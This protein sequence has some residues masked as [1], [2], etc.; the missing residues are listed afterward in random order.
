MF[1]YLS[2]SKYN[3]YINSRQSFVDRYIYGKKFSSIY[4][5][6]GK[7]IAEGLEHRDTKTNSECVKWA[8][9]V[10]P[11]PKEREKKYFVDI[12]GVPLF[13]ILDGE[14][15]GI[16]HEYKTGMHS[17][18]QSKVDENGQLTFYAMMMW[19]KTGKLPKDI[20][21]YWLPTYTEQGK[22]K[23]AQVEPVKFHTQ[24]TLADIISITPKIQKVW[25][26]INNLKEYKEL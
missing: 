17:Y 5:D 3:T 8:R 2:W 7:L 25:K 6:F 11:C 12:E 22:V 19:A 4:M 21:L 1:S 24:R 20:I 13:G 26:E 10:I 9:K 14:D 15:N 16:I 18:T 23:L